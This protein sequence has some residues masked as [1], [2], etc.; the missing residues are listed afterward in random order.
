MSTYLLYYIWNAFSIIMFGGKRL[1][2]CFG[3]K[4]PKITYYC[5]FGNLVH[6]IS[7]RAVTLLG[8]TYIHYIHWYITH[9]TISLIVKLLI[10]MIVKMNHIHTYLTI[11]VYSIIGTFDLL[12]ET[13][14]LF[15]E[16]F[17]NHRNAR[18]ISACESV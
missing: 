11:F 15:I 13:C 6:T 14:M 8:I 9:L 12:I 10:N 1:S 18:S 7:S 16:T 5:S 2:R 3:L 17:H 4:Y